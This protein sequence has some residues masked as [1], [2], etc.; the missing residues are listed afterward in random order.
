MPFIKKSGT[1]YVKID[2]IIHKKD[3]KRRNGFKKKEKKKLVDVKEAVNKVPHSA[4][5]FKQL[6]KLF[7]QPIPQPT[8]IQLLTGILEDDA[9]YDEINE[10]DPSADAREVIAHWLH[11]NMPDKMSKFKKQHQMGDGDGTY[12]VLHGYTA[13]NDH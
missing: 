12:S 9:L 11:L 5:D 7:H 3:A 1:D 10:L 6:S 13:T 2:E 8:A 4:E